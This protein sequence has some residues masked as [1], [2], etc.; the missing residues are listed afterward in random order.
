MSEI[1]VH[2]KWLREV[3]AQMLKTGQS[4]WGNTCM[5][6]AGE[7]EALAAHRDNLLRI[8]ENRPVE[9]KAPCSVCARTPAVQVTGTY[10]LCGPCVL[11]R[12]E[13]N[14]PSDSTHERAG[15]H[16]NGDPV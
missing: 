12:L 11:E 4:M 15:V 7:I 6:A 9:S 5:H 14:A 10:Y 1:N 8:H 16:E 3:A 13:P 2:V